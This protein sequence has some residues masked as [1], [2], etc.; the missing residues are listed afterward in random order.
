MCLRCSSTHGVSTL[1]GNRV[2]SVCLRV[3]DGGD[4]EQ[5]STFD[6]DLGD[7]N[8][9]DRRCYPRA[10]AWVSLP[11]AQCEGAGYGA[12]THARCWTAL[13]G[14]LTFNQLVAVSIP[15]PLT[16]TFNGLL[17]L[18]HDHLRRWQPSGNQLWRRCT[19]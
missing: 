10:R 8:H 13:S 6:R 5:L 19:L 1:C 17:G 14:G 7:G 16:K 15:A 18:R 12:L 11:R 3:R 4:Y 9:C 2:G